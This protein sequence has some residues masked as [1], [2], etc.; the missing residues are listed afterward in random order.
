[1][2]AYRQEAQLLV[3]TFQ[4]LDA[5]ESRQPLASIAAVSPA[6]FGIAVLGIASALRVAL[7]ILLGLDLP[8]F[9]EWLDPRNLSVR[10]GILASAMRYAIE[11]GGVYM[12]NAIQSVILTALGVLILAGILRAVRRSPAAGAILGAILVWALFSP[13]AYAIEVRR[14]PNASVPAGTTVDDTLILMGDA[15]RVDG[16]V[17]GDLIALGRIITVN[18]VVE[19][20]VVAAGQTVDIRGRVDG[21]VFGGGDTVQVEGELLRN[22]YSYARAITVRDSARIGREATAF[23]ANVTVDGT[24]GRDVTAFSGML[25]VRGNVARNITFRG[26]RVSL[27]G[28]ARVGGALTAHVADHESVHIDPSA[29][30]GSSDVRLRAPAPSR[31]S[32][33]RF[34]FWQGIRILGLFH[35]VLLFPVLTRSASLIGQQWRGGVVV[36]NK[37]EDLVT[38]EVETPPVN[39][40]GLVGKD[41]R[42]RAM[43]PMI[44]LFLAYHIEYGIRSERA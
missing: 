38:F 25:D 24:V 32:S 23:A 36:I 14:G 37:F 43:E 4:D 15:I 26:G 31:Y 21:N 35:S 29:S 27:F 1:M 13:A 12:T 41:A 16:T 44:S 34:Y 28:P 33:V 19:G 5:L 30:V 8:Q 3:Q 39:M 17:K 7:G 2:Y 20:D 42:S 40:L 18:G 6:R 22:L 10:L 9:L 11:H